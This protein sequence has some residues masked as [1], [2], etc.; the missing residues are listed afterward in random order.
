MGLELGSIQILTYKLLL[1]PN[2]QF[3]KSSRTKPLQIK[4]MARIRNEKRDQM[5][6]G[7]SSVQ[8]LDRIIW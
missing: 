5:D 6:R 8:E 7:V 4:K 1:T 3:L 2:L